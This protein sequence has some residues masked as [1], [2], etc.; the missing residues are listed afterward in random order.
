MTPG[1][2]GLGEC[3]LRG[4]RMPLRMFSDDKVTAVNVN[5]HSSRSDQI[6]SNPAP[7]SW[8]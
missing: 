8:L 6:P 5:L 3:V 2:T 7:P 1:D 4:R